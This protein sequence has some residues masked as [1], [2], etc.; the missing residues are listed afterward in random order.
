[1]KAQ[2]FLS[3]S[4]AV[5]LVVA[6]NLSIGAPKCTMVQI[7]E[8]PVRLVRNLLIVDGAINGRNIGV[9]LDTGAMRSLLMRA[10]AVRLDVPRRQARGARMFGVGGETRVEIATIDEFTI[11]QNVRKD[12]RLYVV[13]EQNVD[14]GFDVILGEDF[15]RAFDVEFDLAHNA[16]RLFQPKDCDGA[17]LAYWTNDVAGNVEFEP[18]KDSGAEIVL[19]IQINGHPVRAK[20]DSGSTASVLSKDD[21]AVAGVTPETPGVIAAGRTHGL[22]ANAVEVWIG[23]FQSFSIGNET[24]RDTR[25]LFADLYKDTKY[26]STGSHI[27]RNVEQLHPM[28][29]GVD[30]L[31]AHRVLVAHSRHEL[32]FTPT[33]GAVFETGQ[34]ARPAGS[35]AQDE[36]KSPTTGTN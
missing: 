30:F 28:L 9:M 35:P 13:G 33:S 6:S 14:N 12:W 4:L 36:S 27:Q 21:A 22:G 5:G 20:F 29:L 19:S 17:S 24:I 10:S 32:Y 2:T 11:G 31:R 23:P 18:V 3:V 1:M 16:V 7:E 26:T 25:I 34:I 15:F 8:W